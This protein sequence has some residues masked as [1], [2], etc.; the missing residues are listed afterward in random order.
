MIPVGPEDVVDED[1]VRPAARSVDA[2]S[3]KMKR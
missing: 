1:L 2:P 3:A